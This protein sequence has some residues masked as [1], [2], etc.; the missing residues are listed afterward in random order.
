[1]RCEDDANDKRID[2]PV[3]LKK[4]LGTRDYV[5]VVAFTHLDDDHLK[6]SSEFFYLLH[7]KKYQGEGRI[8]I[9]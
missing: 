3:V 7:A 1:M 6:R 5:D 9:K 2:L 4:D 8:K